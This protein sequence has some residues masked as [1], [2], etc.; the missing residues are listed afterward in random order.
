V[1]ST[2]FADD[3]ELSSA[4]LEE[5][6]D[7]VRNIRLWDPDVLIETYRQIQSVRSF[8][9]IRDVDVD[10]Y[11]LDGEPTQVMISTR[12]L[13]SSGVPQTSWEAR[14]LAYT[15][16]YGVVVSP[17]NSKLS[18]GRPSLL[19]ADIPVRD[20]APSRSTSRRSTSARGST[21]TPSPAPT[22]RRSTTRTSRARPSSGSTTVPTASASARTSGAPPS[23]CAS[24]TSTR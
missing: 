2:E 23:P 21:A 11:E 13:D 4:D 3:D 15:H 18:N 19:L 6:A 7:I 9:D 5:N 12:E 14:T 20:N 17:A 24:V 10:R 8:Y 1:R 22:G 16:G